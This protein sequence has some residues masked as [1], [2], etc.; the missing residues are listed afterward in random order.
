VFGL[1]RLVLVLVFVLV[2]RT[3]YLLNGVEVE[4]PSRVI[5]SIRVYA[6]RYE[7]SGLRSTVYARR[8]E[9]SVPN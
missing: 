4:D 7:Q 3:E 1:S 9:L 6:G 8:G 5:P 2:A